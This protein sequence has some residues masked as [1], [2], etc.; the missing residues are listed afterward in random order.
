MKY[1]IHW[2]NVISASYH[3]QLALA[4]NHQ[5]STGDCA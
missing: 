5:R 3:H 4:I 1:A 2:Q